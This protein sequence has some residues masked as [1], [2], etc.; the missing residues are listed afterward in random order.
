MDSGNI[1]LQRA[2]LTYPF[3]PEGQQA[4]IEHLRERLLLND[5]RFRSI[6]P[7][8]TGLITYLAYIKRQ[9]ARGKP[10]RSRGS[11][12]LIHNALVEILLNPQPVKSVSPSRPAASQRLLESAWR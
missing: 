2:L 3:T 5:R 12:R 7:R 8:N 1:H 10:F 4:L 6:H 9:G 11:S